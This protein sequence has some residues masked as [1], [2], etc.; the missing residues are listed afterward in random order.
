M[1]NKILT[2]TACASL[3]LATPL[4][5][6]WEGLETKPYKDVGGV[7]TVC[8]GET[9]VVMKEYSKEECT[10][11]LQRRLPDYYFPAMSYIK[12]DP[13]V[14][15]RAAITSFTY[16]VGLSAFKNSTLLKKTNQGDFKGAC[17][18]LNRWVY[19]GR[20][21]VKG[22]ANRRKDEYALCMEGL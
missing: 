12:T 10:R 21:W 22:L 9:Q 19:V 2:A 17:E 7:M 11:M 8:Y 14:P 20:M 4:I 5:T 16:N 1:R 13:P 18:Q 15:F 3:A 6:K